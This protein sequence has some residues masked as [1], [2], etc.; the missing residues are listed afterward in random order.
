MRLK[1]DCIFSFL[2]PLDSFNSKDK[3]T[4]YLKF[5][6]YDI[7]RHALSIQFSQALTKFLY[8]MGVLPSREEVQSFPRL[9][10]VFKFES[11][12]N[13]EGRLI[14]RP[15]GHRYFRMEISKNQVILE[16]MEA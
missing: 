7:P 8:L 2:N 10:V 13:K 6:V 5:D 15:Y 16:L 3:S 12:T 1:M 14:Y 4:V 9:L 11:Y